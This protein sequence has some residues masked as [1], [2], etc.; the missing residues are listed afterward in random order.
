MIVIA[1]N[2]GKKIAYTETDTVLVFGANELRLDLA[3]CEDDEPVHITICYNRKGKLTTGNDGFT[4]VAE[5]DIPARKYQEEPDPEEEGSSHTEPLPLDMN[6]VELTLWA[7]EE[8]EE[9][10]NEQ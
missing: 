4:Y 5:I 6:Y 8:M 10:A 2:K 3:E 7:L 9:S 1:K